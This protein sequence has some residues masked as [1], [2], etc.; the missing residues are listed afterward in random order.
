MY[1]RCSFV[2]ILLYHRLVSQCPCLNMPE[3]FGVCPGPWWS[4]LIQG[5]SRPG[6]WCHMKSMKHLSW[7]IWHS[8]FKSLQ[9]Q[10][11][12][13][14]SRLKLQYGCWSFFCQFKPSVR[15]EV[16]MPVASVPRISSRFGPWEMQRWHVIAWNSSWRASVCRWSAPT[17]RSDTK[18]NQCPAQNGSW[19]IMEYWIVNF[20]CLKSTTGPLPKK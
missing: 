10:I 19:M 12:E 5:C 9:L 20:E 6:I 15:P 2:Q 17:F 16:T 14:W 8:L 7:H 1:Q 3:S 4:L 11:W 13:P 18:W